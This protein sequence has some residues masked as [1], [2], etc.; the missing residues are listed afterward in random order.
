MKINK[1]LTI[2]L[3]S[4]RSKNLI[5]DHLKKL[6][7]KY[8]IIIIEN[9][10]DKNLEKIVKQ[11][12]KN[13]DIYLRKNIGFGRAINYAAKKIKTKYF[14]VINPDTT[15]YTYTLKNLLSAC[16]EIKTFGSISP[17]HIENKNRYNNKLFVEKKLINGQAMLFETKTYKKINGFDENF[18]LYYEEN[19]FFK[20]CNILNYKLYLITNSFYNHTKIGENN[21]INL[22]L[23]ST[24]FSNFEEKKS[25]YIVGGWHGQWSKYYFYKKY[26]GTLKALTICL[27]KVILN[28]MQ[29]ILYILINPKKVKYKYFKIEG[30]LCSF[31]G[32][33]SFKRSSYDKKY[34]Y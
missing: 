21:N 26:Y 24:T 6:S 20:K 31:L 9:S 16:K 28:F 13:V 14:F 17:I 18:F 10:F 23:H 32:L 25:T 27:P 11:N 34:I 5:L 4:Y 22:N 15:I 19:D 29:L 1:D 2:V 30:F 8:K 3:P 7:N 33:P 12:Y